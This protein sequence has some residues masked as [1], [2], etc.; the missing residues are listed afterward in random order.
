VNFTAPIP[1]GG[2]DYFSL[3]GVPSVN[4]VVSVAPSTTTTPTAAG[5]PAL[6]VWAILLLA[7]MLM[8]YSLWAIRKNRQHQE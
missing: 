3:E 8:G 1:A 6:S 7:S 4:L 5:V 2:S